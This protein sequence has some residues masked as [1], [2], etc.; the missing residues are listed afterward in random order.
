MFL[1]HSMQLAGIVF[2]A[3]TLNHSVISP[4]SG[5][6]SLAAGGDPANVKL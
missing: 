1:Y 5:I 2:Q 4:L 3:C 6:N